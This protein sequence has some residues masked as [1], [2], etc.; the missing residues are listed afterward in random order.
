[1]QRALRLAIR[2][3]GWVSPNPL[4]GAVLVR[5]GQVIGEGYHHGPGLP[6]AEIEA[7]R[8]ATRAGRRLRGST[9]YV[10]LEP[11]CT[12][13]RTP[14]CTEAIVSSGIQRVVVAAV[15]PNPLH[16]GRGLRL[17][18]R[19]GIAVEVGVLRQPATRLNE[20]FNHW[21]VHRRPFVVLKSAMSLDGKIATVAGESKWITGPPARAHAMALRQASDAILVGIN[22]VLADDPRLTVRVE[23]GCGFRRPKSSLWRLVLDSCGRTP[24]G[25]QMI[26]GEIPGRTTV[27]VT[28]RAPASR[29]KRLASRVQVWKAP[30]TDGRVCLEWVI[31]RLGEAGVTQLLVEGGAEVH[32]SFLRQGLVNRV[33]FYYAPKI[34][35]G[36]TATRSVGGQG[37]PSPEQSVRL[38][39]LEW[40]RVGADL[41]LSGLVDSQKTE[42]PAGGDVR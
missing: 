1:M 6:H 14:P 31:A 19:K 16:H 36:R 17:L 22:T 9:L 18:R 24:P 41:F 34:L 42:W 26:V 27:V 4:V 5:G 37:F 33:A 28:R 3:C 8:A 21:I 40:S 20:A 12:H 38:S 2:G 7:I 23:P 39:G 35:G 10:T 11:C 30:I 29:V 13:G 25:A 32:A 15:D